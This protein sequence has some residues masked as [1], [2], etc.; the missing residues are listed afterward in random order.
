MTFVENPHWMNPPVLAGVPLARARAVGVMIHG[1]L[2]R[3]DVMLDAVARLGLDDVGYVLPV[4]YEHSWYPGRYFEPVAHNQ[5]D[6]TWSLS[7]LELTLARVIDAGVPPERTVLAGFGQG[8]CLV[9]ELV[10]RAPRPFAGVAVLAGG[11]LG[12]DGE[13]AEPARVD[14]LPM[15]FACSRHDEWIEL[16]RVQSSARAFERAGALVEVEIYDDREHAIGD[17]AV[18]ATRNLF[19]HA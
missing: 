16:E 11:L 5:P 6:V 15:L 4:A 8:G 17:A 18:A 13:Q 9:A 1:R 10:A 12:P 14:G 3:P 2:Q 19:A 7:A